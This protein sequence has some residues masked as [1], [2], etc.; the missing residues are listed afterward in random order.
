M[1]T[2]TIE[3]TKPHFTDEQRKELI[4]LMLGVTFVITK[5][6]FEMRYWASINRLVI[7]PKRVKNECG[8]CACYAGH[9]PIFCEHKP[10]THDWTDYRHELFG[11]NPELSAFLF[12]SIWTDSWKQAVARTYLML[13]KGIPR[14]YSNHSIYKKPSNLT[15]MNYALEYGITIDEV[16][17]RA[18]EL[19][20]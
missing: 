11:T 8:T 14:S 17:D 5:T 3:Y 18:C 1:T 15:I 13:T 7:S 2:K 9:A 20:V 19:T 4:R 10:N 6:T 12:A 16:Y